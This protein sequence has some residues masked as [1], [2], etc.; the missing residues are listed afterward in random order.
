M[1]GSRRWS[2]PNARLRS[3]RPISLA[4]VPAAEEFAVIV[5]RR[6]ADGRHEPVAVLDDDALIERAIR[7]AA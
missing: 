4:D 5:T 7:K 6:G 3:A 2:P 1:A